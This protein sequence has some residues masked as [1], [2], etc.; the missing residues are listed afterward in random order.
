MNYVNHNKVKFKS[1]I[2]KSIFLYIFLYVCFSCVYIKMPKTLSAKYYQVNKKRLQ[3]KLAKDIK[4]YLK[5]K[6]KKW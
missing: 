2:L 3:K 5:R 4:I 6:K 1:K